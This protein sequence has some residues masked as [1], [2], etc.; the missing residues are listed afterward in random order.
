MLVIVLTVL[1]LEYRS[2]EIE[3]SVAAAAYLALAWKCLQIEDFRLRIPDLCSSLSMLKGS[4]R[5]T[6]VKMNFVSKITLR[7]SNFSRFRCVFYVVES[8]ILKGLRYDGFSFSDV[9]LTSR[10]FCRR[11]TSN[12][13]SWGFVKF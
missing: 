6:I 12:A 3:L 11:C 7:G 1:F 5:C 8:C 9:V 2:K 13:D 4:L 10:V